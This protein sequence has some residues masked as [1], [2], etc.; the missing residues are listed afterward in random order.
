M[1][2]SEEVINERSVLWKGLIESTLRCSLRRTNCED[3]RAG[4]VRRSRNGSILRQMRYE[5]LLSLPPPTAA[6]KHA[7]RASAHL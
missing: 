4:W 1:N 7:F 2:I 6:S 3:L 5:Q